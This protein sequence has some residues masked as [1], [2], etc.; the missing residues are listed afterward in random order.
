MF[1]YIFILIFFILFSNAYSSNKNNIIKNLQNTKNLNF[2]F[3]QNINGKVE[4]GNCTIQYPKKIYC[5]YQKNNKI[6]VS[7]GKSLVIKTVT[8]F[9]RYP[10]N[11][12]TL[13]LILDKKFLIKK[14]GSLK[15]EI[16]DKTYIN[17]VIIENDN[18]INVFFDNKN[19]NLIG[20]Q[21]KDIY[22]NVNIT[23]LSS[24]QKNQQ[25]DKNLFKLPI[26]N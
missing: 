4:F 23:Y 12:T 18:K 22:Q 19:F 20:W 7:N 14:I 26:Q 17:F 8:S 5:K 2:N 3:E 21:T 11:K 9:Y 10:L 1:K 15:E 25:V 24:I 13:N 16:L 6:L